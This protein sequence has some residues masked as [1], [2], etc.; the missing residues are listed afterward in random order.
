M[1]IARSPERVSALAAVI[2]AVVFAAPWLGCRVSNYD[3]KVSSVTVTPPTVTASAATAPKF[4]AVG[5]FNDDSERDVTGDAGWSS[6]DPAV[7]TVSGG[8]VTPLQQ[9]TT[10]ISATVDGHSG[11]AT[12]T[13]TS[14]RLQ[15]IEVTPAS[16]TLANGTSVQL[17][18]TG[19]QEDGSTQDLTSAVT[20]TSS[21]GTVAVG[22]TAGAKGL[23][24]STALGAV[25]CTITATLGDVSGSTTLVVNAVTLTSIAVSPASATIKAGR[26]QQFA[27]SGAFSDGTTH[28]MTAEVAWSSSQASVASVDAKGRATAM[29]AG[30]STIGATSSALLGAKAGSAQ[31]TVQNAS[32]G[33]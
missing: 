15:S 33:Y 2:V 13:V 8:V 31:L 21:A 11:S 10:T 14:A 16:P 9:G 4:A 24:T 26:T 20:W 7:A 5:R 18:A 6:S 22:D 23:A 29:F 30:T 1:S 32:P 28:D 25:T 12:L 3:V 27:A 19:R 17:A